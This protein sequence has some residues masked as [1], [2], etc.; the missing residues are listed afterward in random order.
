MR[1]A[2]SET[3]RGAMACVREGSA[4]EVF[5]AFAAE[6]FELHA[7]SSIAVDTVIPTTFAIW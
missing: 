7:A 5:G 6:A 1:Q 4:L 2:G 3:L